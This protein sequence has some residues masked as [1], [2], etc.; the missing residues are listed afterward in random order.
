[1]SARLRRGAIRRAGDADGLVPPSKGAAEAFGAQVV[2]LPTQQGFVTRIP[3]LYHPWD[4]QHVHL[5]E[6]FD[7]DDRRERDLVYRT[8]CR[9]AAVVVA[10][11]RW[12]ADDLV[13]N[14]GVPRRKVA[15]IPPASP[16]GAYGEPTPADLARVAAAYDLPQTFALYPAQTWPHKNHL[17]LVEALALLASE[18]V[19]LTVVCAGWKNDFYPTIERA[20]REAGVADR[21]RFPGHVSGPDLPA[22]YRLARAFVFPSLFEGWGF[23][24]LESFSA[25]LPVACSDIPVLREVVGDAAQTFAPKRPNELARAL[26][27]VWEDDG[28]RREL[29]ERGRSRS[30]AFTWERTARLCRAHYRRLAGVKLGEEDRALVAETAA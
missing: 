16:L 22:L 13:A 29:T 30:R 10:P 26:R 15:V 9:Q 23:P 27:R 21:L 28:L 6:L 8:L 24:L 3:T 2:H 7:D 19:R 4:L 20:A 11:T 14:L 17:A 1:V 5:P 25:G 18:G 12:G